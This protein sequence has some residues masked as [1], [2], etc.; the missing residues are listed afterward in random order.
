MVSI[1]VHIAFPCLGQFL[2]LNLLTIGALHVC[3]DSWYIQ[4]ELVC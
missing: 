1:F 2:I 4:A 3:M